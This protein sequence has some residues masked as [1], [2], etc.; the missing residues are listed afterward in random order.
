[1][2]FHKG[3]SEVLERWRRREAMMYAL[4]NKIIM[5]NARDPEYCFWKC[6]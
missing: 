5:L 1:M 2:C 4:L 3:S 6:H